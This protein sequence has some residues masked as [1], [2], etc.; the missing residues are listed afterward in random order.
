MQRAVAVLNRLVRVLQNAHVTD[1]S[2][3][4]KTSTMHPQQLFQ[5]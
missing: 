5:F 2:L 1:A 3:A 4:G